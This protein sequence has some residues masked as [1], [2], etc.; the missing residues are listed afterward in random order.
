MIKGRLSHWRCMI[1]LVISP[2]IT[3]QIICKIP[4]GAW[5]C[6]KVNS[7]SL[8]PFLSHLHFI[9]KIEHVA[10]TVSL[11]ILEP[12]NVGIAVVH[13]KDTFSMHFVVLILS[14]IP[15]AVSQVHSTLFELAVF[16][17]TFEDSI[18]FLKLSLA[19]IFTIKE[20]AGIGCSIFNTAGQMASTGSITF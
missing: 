15:H 10:H 2:L 20:V 4:L 5:S 18:S 12:T 13:V 9:F 6:D 1:L 8:R 3:L 11:I 16:E 17:C 7:L 14:L 19:V